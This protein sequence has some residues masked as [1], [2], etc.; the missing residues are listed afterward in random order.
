M[1]PSGEHNLSLGC[2]K[3]G[4]RKTN[5]TAKPALG[6]YDLIGQSGSFLVIIST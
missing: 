2:I 5:A 1:V 6:C 4:T 3:L